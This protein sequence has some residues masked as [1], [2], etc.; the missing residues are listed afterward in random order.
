ML[1]GVAE[2]GWIIVTDAL[3][4]SRYFF[5]ALTKS[6]AVIDFTIVS[7]SL[8]KSE[9]FSRVLVPI[10][11]LVANDCSKSLEKLLSILFLIICISSSVGGLFAMFPISLKIVFK[12]FSEF[13]SEHSDVTIKALP[14][15]G[16][17]L[18]FS[19]W[20]LLDVFSGFNFLSILDV[21]DIDN[22]SLK[23]SV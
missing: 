4:T 13:S 8:R 6:S 10:M 18:N 21:E 23:A 15:F 19:S 7:K 16:F 17:V 12:T 2:A 22:N 3:F 11:S 20:M 5:A 9:L 14:S 1:S